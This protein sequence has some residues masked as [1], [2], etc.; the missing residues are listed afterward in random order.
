MFQ[1]INHQIKFLLL[2]LRLIQLTQKTLL[3]LLIRLN[4]LLY[5][6]LILSNINWLFNLLLW[7]LRRVLFNRLGI[8]L[9]EEVVVGAIELLFEEFLELL[10]LLVVKKWFYQFYE[11]VGVLVVR[12]NFLLFLMTI[13]IVKVNLILLL[14]LLVIILIIITF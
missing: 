6:G 4:F 12:V 14:L 5:H 2:Q 9:L 10:H 13:I 11:L 1:H 3:F 7:F 8:A